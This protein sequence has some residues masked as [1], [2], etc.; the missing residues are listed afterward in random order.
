MARLIHK[1]LLRLCL[2]AVGFVV[3][4]VLGELC[5]RLSAPYEAFGCARELTHFR[6]GKG[7]TAAGKFVVDPELGFQPV[8]GTDLYNEFG[9][10]VNEYDAASKGNRTRVLFIGDSVTARGGIIEAL[11]ARYG[12]DHLEYWNAGVESFNTVQETRF[13]ARYNSAIGS[14]RVILTFHLNDFETTPIAFTDPGGRLVVYAPNYPARELNLFLFSHSRLYRLAAG[15]FKE[16][17]R[18]IDAVVEETRWSLE[19]LKTMLDEDGVGLTVLVFPLLKPY[20]RWDAADRLARGT[21]L[22][23]LRELGVEFYDLLPVI[24]TAIRSG[25]E[26]RESRGDE[27]HPS[28]EACRLIAGHLCK[29]GLLSARPDL[30]DVQ[31]PTSNARHPTSK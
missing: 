14:D 25:V 18:G 9:T 20:A 30:G 11:R 8:L 17:D 24:E 12:D 10:L 15:M 26:V 27:W 19:E 31:L 28:A 4:L 23:I 29:R 16:R 5:L 6:A 2:V 3:A 22:G 13:Y 21:I 1:F 7:P